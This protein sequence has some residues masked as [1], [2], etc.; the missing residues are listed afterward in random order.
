MDVDVVDG[1]GADSVTV[2]DR[3]FFPG[4]LRVVGLGDLVSQVVRHVGLTRDLRRLRIIG[5][6]GPGHQGLGDSRH[7]TNI[8]DS[9]AAI[10]LNWMMMENLADLFRSDGWLELHGCNVARGLEGKLYLGRLA[11]ILRVPVRAGTG[12]QY[13]G[14]RAN[15]TFLWGPWR[16]ARPTRGGGISYHEYHGA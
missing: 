11:S 1:I 16:E 2:H 4:A 5:H 12:L 6:G 15:D 7:A 3:S 9:S 13:G 8:F 14:S 10:S